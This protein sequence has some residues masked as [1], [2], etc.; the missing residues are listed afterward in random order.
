MSTSVNGLS[1]SYLQQLLVSALQSDGISSSSGSSLSATASQSDSS[2]LSPFAQLASTLQQL[3]QS[4]PTVYKQVTAQIATSLLSASQTE[5]SDGN[6]SAASQLSQL[7]TDFTNASKAGNSPTCRISPSREQR[8]RP[9]PSSSRG[10]LH[11]YDKPDSGKS[12][13]P[14]FIA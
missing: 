13:N 10:E 9:S 1:S 4:D 7:S 5:Q 6:T 3:Q 14:K 8:W 2:Q 11:H 12:G